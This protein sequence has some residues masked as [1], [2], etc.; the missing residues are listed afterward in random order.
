MKKCA[1][2][3]RV[4]TSM[5]NEAE[6]SSCEAQKDRIMSYIKSQED[7]EFFK[8]YSD[9]AFSGKD[10]ERPALQEL[11]K[12]IIQKK[13]DV[14]LTYK[15]DRFTR[16]LKDFYSVIEFFEKYNV[17]YVSVTEKFDTSSASGRLLR[18][19]MLT[20]AQFERE[21]TSERIKHKFEQM[22]IKG[23]WCS[24]RPPFG[25]KLENKKV[26]IDKKK[27]SIVRLLFDQF[28]ETG[29]IK[30]VINFVKKKMLMDGRNKNLYTISSLYWT[31]RN[32]IYIGKIRWNQN[33]YD[34]LHEPIISKEL[35]EEAQSLM[36][37]KVK[38]RRL[39]KEFLLSGL[40]QCSGCNSSM[41]NSF[42]NKVKRRY[43]YYKCY[44]VV[45]E[46]SLACKIKEV[47][48]EKLELFLIQNLS[49]IAQDKNYVENLVFRM[50]HAS[51][52]YQGFELKEESFKNLVTRVQQVLI[53][54]KNKMEN[55]TQ[56]EKCLA[57]E[58]TIQKIKFSKDS[59]EVVIS[60]EDTTND[61][62]LNLSG[63]GPGKRSARI[64]GAHPNSCAPHCTHKFELQTGGEGE[65]RTLGTF[66]FTRF[67][68]VPFQPLTHL[69]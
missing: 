59:L 29:S 10:L 37:K 30:A 69:S 20:F 32:P 47:N 52:A 2:Y 14:V 25:Y 54:F 58:R 34:G 4:S 56:M 61:E 17:S 31:L 60:I 49:R 6:Y 16:S 41:T 13:V 46:G 36:T 57:F 35:F 15:I 62:I 63:L 53:N 51:P 65:I 68:G 18:N 55:S 21:M 27:A 26:V 66:R 7:L 5:Q 12:D 33:I 28:V 22:A 8:E 3:S 67:P 40:I 64:R 48:A 39:Y 43:Y 19:I 24:G 1:I 44:K 38:K 9:P 42:T 23:M 45:R 11:F 50:T